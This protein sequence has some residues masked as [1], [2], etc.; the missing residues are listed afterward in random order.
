MGP[1]H[2]RSPTSRTDLITIYALRWGY[3]RYPCNAVMMT[4]VVRAVPRSPEP[5]RVIR[6]ESV[7]RCFNLG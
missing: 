4:F 1:G 3:Q 2:E 7:L 6:R 5:D